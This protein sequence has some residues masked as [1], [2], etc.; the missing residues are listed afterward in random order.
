MWIDSHTHLNNAKLAEYGTVSQV[1]AA[2]NQAGVQG[3]LTINCRM[4][5]EFPEVVGI[6]NAHRNVWCSLGTHPHDAG[7]AQ[8]KTVTTQDIID[9][10]NQNKKVIGLGE[11]GLDYFYTHST[12]EDQATSFRKH[13][14]AAI[15][16]DLPLII[17]A[18]DADQDTIQ[19]LREEGAGVN[20]RLRGVMHCFSSTRWMAEQAL[21]IGF[22]ISLSG[23]VTF[24]KST[25]L[26]SIAR[27]VPVDR[28][29]VETDAPYL[30]PMPHR[31]K[32]N[33][34]ALVTH[35]G[36]YVADLKG[37]SVSAMAAQTT[38]NFFTLFNRAKDA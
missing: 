18:R 25:D 23:I 36:A 9:L 38:Q 8:E 24:P 10:V 15:A 12:P 31:G 26:Q 4:R 28:L 6:A 35:T 16:C 7:N 17:H 21:D 29:L 11:T 27:D 33:Q 34:P 14:H 32:T 22:Y 3:I 20:P 5:D 19:I 37:M 2:A 13:I 30:A 1:V